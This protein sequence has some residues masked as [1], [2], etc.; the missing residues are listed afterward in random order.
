M[1][2]GIAG[3]IPKV[4]EY[5]AMGSLQALGFA[6]GQISCAAIGVSVVGTTP[7]G[8]TATR[9]VD[10]GSGY[11]DKRAPDLHFGLRRRNGPDRRHG[12]EPAGAPCHVQLPAERLWL[13]FFGHPSPVTSVLGDIRRYD[14]TRHKGMMRRA[15]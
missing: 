11:T 5:A 13:T 4:A 12:R 2:A 10:G 6:N 9:Q 14:G 7:G 1:P 3:A 8:P 15:G